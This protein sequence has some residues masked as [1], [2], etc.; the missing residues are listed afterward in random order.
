LPPGTDTIA[1]VLGRNKSSEGSRAIPWALALQV[2][3]VVGRRVASLSNRDRD[4]LL[5]LLRESRGWPGR[6]G[7]R[8]RA[9]LRKLLGKLDMRSMARELVPLARGGR[10]RKRG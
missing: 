4:R 8:D 9:E 3:V 2:L 7:E 10:G 1:T 5:D 6:L